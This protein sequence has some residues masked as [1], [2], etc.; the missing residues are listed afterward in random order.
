MRPDPTLWLAVLGNT[1]FWFLGPLFLQTVLVYGNDVLHLSP[2]RI[3]LLDAALALGVGVGSGL[4]GY[5]S[6]NKIEYSLIPI[7]VLGMTAMAALMG[8]MTDSFVA[9]TVRPAWAGLVCRFLRQA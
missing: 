3:A 4:A 8:A 2:S 9:A 1:Y 7:G 5:L 6:A